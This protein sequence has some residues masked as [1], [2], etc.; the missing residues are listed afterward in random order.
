MLVALSV[1]IFFT[2]AYM[3][4]KHRGAL[5]KK[6]EPEPELVLLHEDSHRSMLRVLSSASPG[7][8]ADGD[9]KGLRDR[10]CSKGS[11]AGAGKDQPG[12]QLV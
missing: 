4:H 5:F 1:F 12:Q 7:S 2:G 8:L 11:D 3:D 6:S 10:G 9:S